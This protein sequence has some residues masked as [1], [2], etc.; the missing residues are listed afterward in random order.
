METDSEFA[1]LDITGVPAVDTLVAQHL[2]KTVAAARLMGTE[3]IISGIRPQIA[4]TR[5]HWWESLYSRNY[6]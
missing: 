4:Q 6:G 2:L 1:I 5:V 3:C